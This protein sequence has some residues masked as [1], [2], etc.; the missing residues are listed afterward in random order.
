MNGSLESAAAE[1]LPYMREV[2]RRLHALPE[3]S[4]CEYETSAYLG[5][6]LAEL[7]YAPRAAH[8]GLIADVKGREGGRT[9]AFRADFDALPIRERTGLPFASANG[10]MHACGHDGHTAMLL[11][12]A[13]HFAAHPPAR[14]LRLIFQFGEE[15]DGGAATMIER[16]ALDGVDEIYAFHLC[17]DLSKGKIGTNRAALFAGVVEF[18]VTFAGK[19][20]HCAAKSEGAD[21]LAA[22]V[23]FVTAARP[24]S[25][26]DK[27][28]VHAG[29]ITGG[30]ARNV[31]ADAVKTE[32][33]FRYFA[34]S[35]RD[36]IVG[37]L[38]K[39]A[40]VCG[41]KYGARGELV[42]RAEYPPVVN[43]PA[44]VDKLAGVTTIEEMPGRFTAEDF[45]FY[46]ERVPGCMAWLGV[47]DEDH[48]SP[49]H[50]DTFDFDESVLAKGAETFIKLAEI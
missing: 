48:H 1:L 35:D 26:S 7:G 50:S 44:C 13:K 29:K 41:A 23:D 32:C 12:A 28:L 6:R 39:L 11:G 25:V 21:A 19:S 22:A 16:G 9:I 45:A 4:S 30:S 3:L 49:L 8:T 46:L 18:D 31:V 37:D 2:R 38:R 40:A 36:R 47:R 43:D 27:T 5:A 20:S 24:Y 33:S 42:I 14:D 15:G 34:V 17:P 10:N